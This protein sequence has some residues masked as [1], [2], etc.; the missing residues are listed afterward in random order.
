VESRILRT[1]VSTS[2]RCNHGLTSVVPMDPTSE[3]S[4]AGG[5]GNATAA[6]QVFLESAFPEPSNS[7]E[8]LLDGLEVALYLGEAASALGGVRSDVER[9]VPIQWHRGGL[10]SR[11][12]P[13]GRRW[14]PGALV[15]N[16]LAARGYG[17]P[18]AC[19]L[20][21]AA[22]RDLHRDRRPSW[23]RRDRDQFG[24]GHSF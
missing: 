23:P 16:L 4:V 13:S 21:P 15:R 22:R 20:Q 5:T 10:R 17:W 7:Q 6:R 3:V 12:V 8:G 2:C 18:A 14:P 9:I 1:G 11:R 19:S 24:P